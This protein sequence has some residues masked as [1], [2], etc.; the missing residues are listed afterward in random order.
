MFP[1][2]FRPILLKPVANDLLTKSSLDVTRTVHVCQIKSAAVW[3]QNLINQK[4]VFSRLTE[5]KLGIGDDH[6]AP[7]GVRRGFAINRQRRLRQPLP[8]AVPCDRVHDP[9]RVP[10]VDVLVVP[11]VGLRRGRGARRR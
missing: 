7:G 6:T 3:G 11:L 5:L 10:G 8:D 2:G 4:Q 1:N 9:E